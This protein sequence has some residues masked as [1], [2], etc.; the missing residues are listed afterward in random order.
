LHVNTLLIGLYTIIRKENG[1]IL[2]LNRLLLRVAV[3]FCHWLIHRPP[4]TNARAT[5][6]KSTTLTDAFKI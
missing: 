3:V 5:N 6:L 1:V 4:N 2:T